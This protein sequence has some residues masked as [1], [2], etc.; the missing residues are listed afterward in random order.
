M[1]TQDRAQELLSQM[2]TPALTT[3]EVAR[4]A[5][6]KSITVSQWVARGYLQRT[7][8]RPGRGRAAL[9]TFADLV[10]ALAFASLSRLGFP[11]KAVVGDI[12]EQVMLCAGHRLQ[13]LAG[14]WGNPNTSQLGPN[15][16][17]YV[18]AWHDASYGISWAVASSPNIPGPLPHAAWIVLDSHA[19]LE[20]AILGLEALK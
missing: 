16:K 1:V 10:E 3:E 6:V 9:F 2:E 20:R 14:V 17:R 19:L 4:L 5:G 18:L 12:S 8:V 11:P 15:F 13:A 7:G